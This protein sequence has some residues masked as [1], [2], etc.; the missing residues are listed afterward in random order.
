[1]IE[2]IAGRLHVDGDAVAV[3][4]QQNSPALLVGL[5]ERFL[6]LDRLG[7]ALTVV[8]AAGRDPDAGAAVK[9]RAAFLNRPD[10]RPDAVTWAALG[11][12]RPG[13]TG[14]RAAA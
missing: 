13:P 6:G 9:V 2:A 11:A 1:M 7:A 4:T 14:G 8:I 3:P 12:R 10:A 5:I